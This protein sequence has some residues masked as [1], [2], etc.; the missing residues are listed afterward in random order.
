MFV[1]SSKFL[2]VALPSVTGAIQ[3]YEF[4]SSKINQKQKLFRNDIEPVLNARKHRILLIYKCWPD[5]RWSRCKKNSIRSEKNRIQYCC[6]QQSFVF[7]KFPS[8]THHREWYMFKKTVILIRMQQCCTG[9]TVGLLNLGVAF[10]KT[11]K[12][13]G[14]K[15]PICEFRFHVKC[16]QKEI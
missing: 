1:F 4:M 11:S 16:A 7:I 6:V 13:I 9:Y 15:D 8:S 10:L 3:L 5:R 14:V 2:L 12:N